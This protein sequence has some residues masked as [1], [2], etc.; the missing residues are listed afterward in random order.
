MQ[1]R[2]TNLAATRDTASLRVKVVECLKDAIL[3]GD[4]LPGQK[5]VERELCDQLQISRPLLREA[6]RQ[7]QAEGLIVNVLHRGQSVATLSVEDAR[8]IYQVRQ[9]L[10]RLAAE[11]FT[12]HASSEQVGALRECFTRLR[13]NPVK[14]DPRA[15]LQ[16]KNRFY[17]LL[18]E[19]SGNTVVGQMMTLL[20]NRVT[21]LRRFTLSSPGRTARSIKELESI[22]K[23]VEA[24]NAKRAGQ[25]CADHIGNA[26]EIA[27]A[28]FAH[29]SVHADAD[30]AP[31]AL[32]TVTRPK[33]RRRVNGSGGALA[34]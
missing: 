29:W 21:M 19:G 24:R 20:R 34:L 26:A 2:L 17:D 30:A 25:M 32:E 27:L 12:R 13:S 3:Y 33:R 31:K 5:L 9:A 15:L 1:N 22:V 7:L 16:Q 23:A 18:A 10:E 6:L 28:G 4:F 8:N 14:K 11:E